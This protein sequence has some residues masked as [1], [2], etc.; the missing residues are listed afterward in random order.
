ML[1]FGGSLGCSDAGSGIGSEG[2]PGS[3]SGRLP[4][5]G[6]CPER[7]LG[8][9]RLGQG[10][11]GP[12]EQLQHAAHPLQDGQQDGSTHRPGVSGSGAFIGCGTWDGQSRV[13]GAW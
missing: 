4:T 2:R 12:P 10:V 1:R 5:G 6:A 7:G 11:E 3:D 9:R 13:L 8:V